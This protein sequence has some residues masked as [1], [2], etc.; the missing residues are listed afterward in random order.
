M[1]KI[2]IISALLFVGCM[3]ATP[4]FAQSLVGSGVGGGKTANAQLTDGTGG[5]AALDVGLSPSSEGIYIADTTGQNFGLELGS[6]KGSKEYG[7]SS[8]SSLVYWHDCT[9]QITNGSFA[10]SGLTSITGEPFGSQGWN[11]LGGT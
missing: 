1:K 5:Q 4:S 9:A 10:P 2:A 7:T 6:A 8:Y 3:F 11:I